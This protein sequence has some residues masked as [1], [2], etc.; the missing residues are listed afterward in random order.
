MFASKIEL[1]EDSSRARVVREV[2]SG[3]ETMEVSLPAVI[4]T[5][6]RL[7]EPRY[8]AL[9]AIIKARSKPFEKI[10]ASLLGE[11]PS[12]RINILKLESPPVRKSGRKVGSVDELILALREEARVI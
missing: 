2:D 8:V 11:R 9:P 5:D 12:T 10:E 3:R 1:S 6:L 7:N 4:T